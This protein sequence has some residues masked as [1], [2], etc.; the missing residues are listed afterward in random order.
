MRILYAITLSE[1]GGAQSVV[2]NLANKLSEKHEIIIVAGEGDGKMWDMLNP[3]VKQEHS[4]H[5]KRAL[6]PIN[7]LLTILEFWKLYFKYKP[8]I[9]HLNSS[10]V[11]ILGRIAFPSDKTLYTVHGFDSIRLVYRKFL[12]VERYLQKACKAI[13]GVS[14]Y[15]E[16]NLKNEG[17]YHQVG[18]IYNGVCKPLM[19]ENISFNLPTI[20]KKTILC[21]ARLSP[22]KR[23]DLF[24]SVAKLL[25]E[26]AFIWIGNQDEIKNH[27]QNTF[28][29]GN[30]LNACKFNAAADLFMLP[31]DY[32][33][34]PIVIIEAMSFGK[35]IVASNVGGI[36]EIV[37]DKKNGYVVA[38]TPE[39]FAS[40]IRYILEN[41]DIYNAFSKNSINRY[42][43]DLTVDKMAES[44]EK[45]YNSLY[46][47]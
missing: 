5:L 7:D 46:T 4:K 30:I 19:K 9:I 31:S 13:I 44:Y 38:N 17:I 12:P 34:L 41:K 47:S 36:N 11:G 40:K 29:M 43:K 28:F 10:K 1:L 37:Q 39:A 32:E 26:Y 20:Y 3:Q 21:I 35:P 8:D 25:P 14:R 6:S 42:N 23:K 18:C 22:P 24:I 45:I 33:G 15:D 27:P 16:K 2:V